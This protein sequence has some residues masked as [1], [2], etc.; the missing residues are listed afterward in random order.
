MIAGFM[1]IIEVQQNLTSHAKLHI[2][3]HQN[4]TGVTN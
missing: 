1:T 4:P 2:S 3:H